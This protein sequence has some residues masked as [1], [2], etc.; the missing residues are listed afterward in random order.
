MAYPHLAALVDTVDLYGYG[1]DEA[2]DTAR[3]VLPLLGRL[4]NLK[5]V[6]NLLW[7]NDLTADQAPRS[8]IQSLSINLTALRWVDDHPCVET[9]LT[10]STCNLL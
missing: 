9:S 6:R 1:S 5:H 7:S 3:D 10:Y 2:V 8:Q 4:P